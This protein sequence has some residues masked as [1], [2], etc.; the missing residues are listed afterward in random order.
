MQWTADDGVSLR[1]DSR[2]NADQSPWKREEAHSFFLRNYIIE[3]K[4]HK[5]SLRWLGGS[6]SR[7]VTSYRAR[8][9]SPAGEN[10]TSAGSLAYLQRR[11]A[12]GLEETGGGW[13]RVPQR[14]KDETSTPLPQ[15]PASILHSPLVWQGGAG[16]EKIKEVRSEECRK[17]WS[18]EQFR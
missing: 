15:A 9:R 17:W 18:C 6:R 7:A 12:Q 14:K 13:Q 16:A 10:S 1:S 4:R 3:T 8:P 2:P 11:E 5:N